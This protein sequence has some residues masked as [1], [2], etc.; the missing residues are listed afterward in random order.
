MFNKDG[1][2]SNGCANCGKHFCTK[3]LLKAHINLCHSEDDSK[4]VSI[5]GNIT[6]DTEHSL[7]EHLRFK[8]NRKKFECFLCLKLFEV[9]SDLMQHRKIEHD[10]EDRLE[11]GMCNTM[12]Q[13]RF[14]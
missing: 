2:L 11:C 6:L 13:S 8:H 7:Q 1:S 12:F 3:I 14:S 10:D 4:S 5:S 9:K